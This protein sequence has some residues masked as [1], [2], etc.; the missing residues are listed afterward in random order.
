MTCID[1]NPEAINESR[2]LSGADAVIAATGEKMN[3]S[4]EGASTAISDT[5]AYIA[6]LCD[7]CAI[8]PRQTFESVLAY[9]YPGDQ[10]DGPFCAAAPNAD[11]GEAPLL[12]V[13]GQ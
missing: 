12:E 6:H 7:W 11:A 2:A 13:I 1:Q 10:E 4:V 5:L 3:L 9:S 8:D